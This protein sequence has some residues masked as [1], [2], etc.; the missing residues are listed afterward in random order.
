MTENA[1]VNG[2]PV[3]IS[4]LNAKLRMQLNKVLQCKPMARKESDLGVTQSTQ[5]KEEKTQCVK[6]NRNVKTKAVYCEASDPL[7]TL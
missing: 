4:E 7:D 3:K 6:C 5:E 2:K 1:S